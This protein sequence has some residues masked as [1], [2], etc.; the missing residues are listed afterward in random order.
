MRPAPA[1]MLA[2]WRKAMLCLKETGDK[3]EAR[4]PADA[5]GE[6]SSRSHRIDRLMRQKGLTHGNSYAEGRV[7]SVRSVT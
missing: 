7:R 6:Q 3:A 4:K 1:T 2:T 5:T